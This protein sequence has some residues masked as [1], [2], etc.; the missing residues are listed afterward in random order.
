MLKYATPEGNK[1]IKI[2]PQEAKNLL[3][4]KKAVLLDIRMP[5]EEDILNDSFVFRIDPLNLEKH[6]IKL[7]KD[8]T[9]IVACNTQN[10][11]PFAALYLKE[12]GYNA[13]YLLEGIRE[14]EK[15]FKKEVYKI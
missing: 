6:H 12:K 15:E 8:K 14:L 4:N 7:P 2:T 1:E 5:D 9:I 11:S 3:K 13:K 10:R